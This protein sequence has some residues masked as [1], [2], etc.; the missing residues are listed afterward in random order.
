MTGHEFPV[1]SEEGLQFRVLTHRRIGL[2][3][4]VMRAA[5]RRYAD[6][7]QDRL[8]PVQE[9]FDEVG[10][11]VAE[12]LNQRRLEGHPAI[13]RKIQIG[14]RIFRA[15]IWSSKVP[16]DPRAGLSRGRVVIC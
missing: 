6:E 8:Q 7:L 13:Q 2:A 15:H 16:G 14:F 4:E 1:Q 5:R 3:V 12:V 9:R 10:F 11:V